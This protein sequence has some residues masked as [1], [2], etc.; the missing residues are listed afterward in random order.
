LAIATVEVGGSGLSNVVHRWIVPKFF[1]L[2]NLGPKERKPSKPSS[3]TVC[4][5]DYAGY[6]SATMRASNKQKWLSSENAT[7][8]ASSSRDNGSPSSASQSSGTEQQQTEPNMNVPEEPPLPVRIRK[9]TPPDPE[10]LSKIGCRCLVIDLPGVVHENMSVSYIRGFVRVEGKRTVGRVKSFRKKFPLNHDQVVTRMLSAFLCQGVLVIVAPTKVAASMAA[11]A[12]LAHQ[13]LINGYSPSKPSRPKERLLLMAYPADTLEGPVKFSSDF[14]ATSFSSADEAKCRQSAFK[15]YVA[16]AIPFDESE[17]LDRKENVAQTKEGM[18]D[19]PSYDRGSSSRTLAKHPGNFHNQRRPPNTIVQGRDS[20]PKPDAP[21]K[22][23]FLRVKSRQE[24]AG[25]TPSTPSTI[26]GPSR[27][28]NYMEDTEN[29]AILSP[30]TRGTESSTSSFGDPD[31]PVVWSDDSLRDEPSISGTKS[32]RIMEGV[33]IDSFRD[34]RVLSP[35]LEHPFTDTYEEMKWRQTSPDTTQSNDRPLNWVQFDSHWQDKEESLMVDTME[36]HSRVAQF[37]DGRRKVEGT[38]ATIGVPILLPFEDELVNREE[39]RIRMDLESNPFW[40]S[41]PFLPRISSPPFTSHQHFLSTIDQPSTTEYRG[42]VIPI[43]EHQQ[44]R[45][46]Y[47]K[48]P[49]PSLRRSP[50]TSSVR[51]SVTWV[52]EI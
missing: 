36:N 51:K 11:A 46:D 14:R 13:L 44:Q 22:K 4:W 1:G 3:F 32:R 40:Q 42:P 8:A 52:D 41:A 18:P 23:P 6:L 30:G 16:V 50:P 37:Q 7:R 45:R 31:H 33:Y 35:I 24:V 26:Y 2:E 29:Q 48:P 20:P 28:K 49:S 19:S 43:R 39:H 47:G 25:N 34:D 27:L 12:M 9:A 17:S 10:L 5:F 21:G 15:P 38:T